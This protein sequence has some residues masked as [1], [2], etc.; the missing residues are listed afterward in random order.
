M[1]VARTPPFVCPDPLSFQASAW[2]RDGNQQLIDGMLL[3]HW[4]PG[5][6]L[7]VFRTIQANV[8][9]A[10]NTGRINPGAR[11]AFVPAWWSPGTGLRGK[12]TDTVFSA[13]AMSQKQ[14]DIS[15]VIPGEQLKGSVQ[16]KTSLV[17]LD[18]P[19]KVPTDPLAALRPGSVLWHEESLLVLEGE[20]PRFPASAVNFSENIL[21]D[22]TACWRLE[23]GPRELEA[24]AMGCLRLW[25]NKEHQTFY[26][27]MVASVPTPEEMA[28]RSALRFSVA[29]EMLQLAL[30]CADDLE[31]GIFDY[32]STGR[33]FCD[34]VEQIF[35][36]W[37][38][39]RAKQF[40]K[41]DPASFSTR[42]QS[43]M[44]LFA[45]LPVGSSL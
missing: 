31:Q 42:L 41:R 29:E 43:R 6:Q 13:E 39:R 25:I 26:R 15:M 10:M 36:D 5:T 2:S 33:V 8:G 4:D 18:R 1:T 20:A 28:I 37:G 40:R 12:G 16:L 24:P 38:P 22:V 45:D 17:L 30:D 23:W 32:G 9:L 14:F 3:P 11:L 35:P 44:H 27:A 19:P 21:G 7:T 34:L